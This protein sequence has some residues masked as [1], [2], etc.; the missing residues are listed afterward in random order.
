MIRL[1]APCFT[2]APEPVIS[3]FSNQFPLAVSQVTPSLSI[4][5]VPRCFS[6]EARRAAS[7]CTRNSPL[8]LLLSPESVRSVV[9]SIPTEPSP[10]SD[11]LR[12]LLTPLPSAISIARRSLRLS[13]LMEPWLPSPCAP[14]ISTSAPWVRLALPVNPILVP[15]TVRLLPVTASVPSPDS[16]LFSM[17]PPLSSPG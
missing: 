9:F 8:K 11:L 3:F 5:P 12:L 13:K 17:M 1:P 7:F 2:R 14:F 15:C 16:T 6:S 10:D 4:S